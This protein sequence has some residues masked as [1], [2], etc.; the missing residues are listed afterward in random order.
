MSGKFRELIL[1]LEKKYSQNVVILVDEYDKSILDNITESERAR[2][3]VSEI[4][5]L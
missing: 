3:M 5:T 1:E 2:E 4:S